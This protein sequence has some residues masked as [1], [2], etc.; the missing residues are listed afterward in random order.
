MITCTGQARRITPMMA[1]W[2]NLLD[3]TGHNAA[4][5][6]SIY[7]TLIQPANGVGEETAGS[8]SGHAGNSAT[9][10]AGIVKSRAAALGSVS[11]NWYGTAFGHSNKAQ[12]SCLQV[13]LSSLIQ[14]VV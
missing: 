7:W 12:H 10:H 9:E 3:V 13:A 5:R 14:S 6:W 8:A 2:D 11:S 1:F 4:S